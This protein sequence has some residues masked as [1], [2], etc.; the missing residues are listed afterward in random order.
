MLTLFEGAPDRIL[1]KIFNQCVS[2][3]SLE[4]KMK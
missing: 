1:T 3:L 2:L 4:N